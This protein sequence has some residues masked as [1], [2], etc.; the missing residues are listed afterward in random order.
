MHRLKRNYDKYCII[1]NIDPIPCPSIACHFC[2]WVSHHCRCNIRIQMASC[3]S[4]VSNQGETH[5]RIIRNPLIFI[6][7]LHIYF[8]TRK[9]SSH[10]LVVS[11][12]SIAL[13]VWDIY[14]IRYHLFPSRLPHTT[15]LPCFLLMRNLWSRIGLRNMTPVN[16]TYLVR[17][18]V[19]IAVTMK[20][21]VFWDVG[22]YKSHTA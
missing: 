14:F 4:A 1:R 22:S 5:F 15:K 20:N 11:S 19:F 9:I 2:N 10:L 7:T 3:P 6:S 16:W 8:F 18:E 13:L 21:V 12:E 17:F